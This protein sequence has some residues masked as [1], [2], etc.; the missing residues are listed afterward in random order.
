MTEAKRQK[1]VR[2]IRDVAQAPWHPVYD[3]T[4]DGR[5]DAAIRWLRNERK[6]ADAK[7]DR[8]AAG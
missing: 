4:G 1:I 3:L 7:L 5:A 2:A 6:L 8:R